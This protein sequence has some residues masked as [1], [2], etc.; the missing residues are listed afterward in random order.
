MD[1]IAFICRTCGVEY[2]P[3]EIPP[4][5]C[6]ICEDERQYVPEGGQQWTTLTEINS[7]HKNVIEKVADKLYAIYTV[8]HFGIGQR[9]HLLV[10]P[11]GNILWDCISNLD[12]STVDIIQKLGGIKAIGISH[13]HY[14][15]TWVQWSRAFGD[16]P[17]YIHA[18]DKEW[19]QR[20]STS[21][22]LWEGVQQELWDNIRLVCCGGH[23][24][25]GNILYWPEEKA[26]LTGD[27]IQVCPD[28][29]SVSFM[30]SYPN[31]IPLPK[32]D[33]LQ[34]RACL[35]P[36]DYEVLYGAFGHYIRSGG[37]QAV[38]RSLDR[39]LAIFSEK[40]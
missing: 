21:L 30:Y 11:G 14:F 36:L 34:I 37:K 35:E 32:K 1:K 28:Q 4:A 6:P 25:G 29:K 23:F 38:K 8:P 3:S 15:S 9:A 27:V 10:T 33:I 40:S 12:D 17:V 2:E 13:P 5:H 7:Q 39:Y 24:A 19:I 26:L 18:R 22:R 20:K 16:V 31:Y